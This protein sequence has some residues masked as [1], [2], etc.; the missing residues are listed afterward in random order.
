MCG[1]SARAVCLCIVHRCEADAAAA[2]CVCGVTRRSG[3]QRGQGPESGSR[4]GPYRCRKN[5]HNYYTRRRG[6]RAL[7]T[8]TQVAV[9]SKNTCKNNGQRCV[10][11]EAL[12]IITLFRL[13]PRRL[14]LRLRLTWGEGVVLHWLHWGLLNPLGNGGPTRPTVLYFGEG[15]CNR[16]P[17]YGW[18]H[19]WPLSGRRRWIGWAL[20]LAQCLLRVG[21]VHIFEVV[22]NALWLLRW[23]QYRAFDLTL[24]GAL[25]LVEE[26][27][28]ED[29]H[30]VRRLDACL[31]TKFDRGSGS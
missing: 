29:T 18:S 4:T 12:S 10:V 1:L 14:A 13:W 30:G 8:V 24:R 17:L 27:G 5:I 31:H 11:S 15:G 9:T 25:V 2:T 28:E 7:P 6:V 16:G 3:R 19:G 26:I 20:N 21:G 22:G 23:W